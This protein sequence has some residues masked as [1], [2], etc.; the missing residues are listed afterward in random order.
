[1][2]HRHHAKTL[3]NAA[4]EL[5]RYDPEHPD[6]PALVRI[7]ATLSHHRLILVPDVTRTAGYLLVHTDADDNWQSLTM[8]ATKADAVKHRATMRR[9][10]RKMRGEGVDV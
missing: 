7:A 2:N 8:H 9:H 1:M 4:G 10:W 5:L 3:R 6:A